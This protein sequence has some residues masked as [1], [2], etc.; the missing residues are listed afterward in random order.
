MS[1]S[2]NFGS[3]YILHTRKYRDTSLLIDLFSRDE[4]RYTLVAR[5][6]RGK[7]SRF[8]LQLFA[9]V[10]VSSFGGGELKTASAIESN[11]LGYRL[12]GKNLFIGLYLNELLFNVI[13]KFDPFPNLFDRYGELL[14][15]LQSD[16]FATRNLRLFEISLLADLGYG[17]SFDV[18]SL[19]GDP[20]MADRSY[21]YVIEDGFHYASEG[22][23]NLRAIEGRHI[24]AIAQGKIDRNGD[25]ILRDIVRKSV[26]HLLGGKPLNSRKLFA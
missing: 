12:S 7:K 21:F 6:A 1:S 26:D 2:N 15:M 8:N 20:I 19:T 11:G 14:A 17:I 25:K 23:H 22:K 10:M 16:T 24:L 18:E 13:G 3:A 4:G 9:P 5:G